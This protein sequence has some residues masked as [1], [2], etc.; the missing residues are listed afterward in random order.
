[1]Y[2]GC[3]LVNHISKVSGVDFLIS[4]ALTKKFIPS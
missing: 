1:M 3:R 4:K 2:A